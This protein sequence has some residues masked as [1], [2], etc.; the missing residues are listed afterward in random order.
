MTPEII[1]DGFY[2]LEGPRWRDG[3]L[4][5]SDM[6]DA[7]VYR[8]MPGEEAKAVATVPKSPSG[9]GWL[10]NGD[11]LI[12]SMEDQ[13]VMRMDASG[14]LHP[15]A[16]LSAIA[17]RRTN[18]MIVDK[19]GRAYVGNFGFDFQ[20]G[21][22]PS[23]TK[24]AMIE[25]DG[26]AKVAADGLLFPNGMVIIE[27]TRT[28]VIAE[29]FGACLTAFDIAADGSLSNR[30][31]WAALSD[32]AVPDGI[33]LD[34]SGAI[35]VASPTTGECLRIKEG[36][37]VLERVK[38]GRQAIAC[39]L[40]GDD[41][42]TLYISTAEHTHYDKCRELHSARIEAIQVEIPGAGSP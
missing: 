24:L 8:L 19:I 18:D 35:W 23:P 15:H 32:G 21:E 42:R 34:Q 41:M 1:A 6:H 38:T 20:F 7:R 39:N 4:W 2:F 11:M 30:R 33:C 40:G 31:V 17:D 10:P 3:A 16:D 29:T 22:P 13:K 25:P 27:E 5:F 9:L 26:T 28:L 37:E 36:G 14:E 12:V